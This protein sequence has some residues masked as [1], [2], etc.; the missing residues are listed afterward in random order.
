MTRKL[1]KQ[2]ALYAVQLCEAIAELPKVRRSLSDKPGKFHDA[3]HLELSAAQMSDGEGQ[4]SDHYFYVPPLLGKAI[5]DAA[6]KIIRDEMRR[7]N[8]AMP[9]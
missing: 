6:E 9:T 7:I 1:T 4:G 2:D 5:I 8:V 3:V